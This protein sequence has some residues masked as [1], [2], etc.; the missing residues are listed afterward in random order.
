ML[1]LLFLSLN[2]LLVLG[3]VLMYDELNCHLK[4]PIVQKTIR[5][6]KL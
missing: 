4:V 5:Y 1:F 6:N 2:P 3:R